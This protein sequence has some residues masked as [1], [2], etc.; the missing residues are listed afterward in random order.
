[1]GYFYSVDK[2]PK[3]TYTQS[4]EGDIFYMTTDAGYQGDIVNGTLAHEFQHMIYF[5]QHYNRG[6][7]STYTW[8]NE[9]LSQAAEYYT[10]YTGTT[11]I[12]SR[13]S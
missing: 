5:D 9:A 7:T 13:I 11:S 4:N 2:Y 6:V 8:L 12:G 3:A 10:G 1:M